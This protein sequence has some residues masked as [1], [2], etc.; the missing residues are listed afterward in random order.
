M[1]ESLNE[2]V[3]LWK[4]SCSSKQ[5]SAATGLQI[6]NWIA[7]GRWICSNNKNY[8]W[9]LSCA[10]VCLL[11]V[12][13]NVSPFPYTINSKKKEGHFFKKCNLNKISDNKI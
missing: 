7:S 2:K 12:G 3:D 6:L 5:N 8:Y 10:C 13:L 11:A 9:L 1:E 4:P